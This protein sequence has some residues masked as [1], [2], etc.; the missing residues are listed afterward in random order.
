MFKIF[1]GKEKKEKEF[2]EFEVEKPVD[3]LAD[4]T[5]NPLAAQGRETGSQL[6]NSW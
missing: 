6:E 4:F 5:F 1:G 3:C 2:L